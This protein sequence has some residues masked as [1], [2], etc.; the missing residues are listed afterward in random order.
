[1]PGHVWHRNIEVGEKEILSEDL[2]WIHLAQD[3]F[4]RRAFVNTTM[5]LQLSNYH[6]L[7]KESAS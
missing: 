5:N 2:D 6:L 3:W 1:M 7:K 4:K